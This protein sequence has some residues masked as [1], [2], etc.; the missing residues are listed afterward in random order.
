MPKKKSSKSGGGAEKKEEKEPSAGSSGAQPPQAEAEAEKPTQEPAAKDST[1]T[2]ASNF[3]QVFGKVEGS[4]V[5]N[6]G[7]DGVQ[8][9]QTGYDVYFGG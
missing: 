3:D 7:G 8:N 2:T 1:P 9:P 4:D 5:V 6:Q